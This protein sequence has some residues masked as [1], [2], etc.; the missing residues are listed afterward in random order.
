MAG[1]YMRDRSSYNGGSQRKRSSY[2]G[3][4]RC[5]QR[6]NRSYSPLKVRASATCGGAIASSAARSAIVRATR[7]TR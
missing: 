5:K 6:S 3:G 2:N 7:R 1:S 4:S